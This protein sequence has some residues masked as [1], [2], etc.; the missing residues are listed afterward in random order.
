MD[1]WNDLDELRQTQI[2]RVCCS[3]LFF[4]VTYYLSPLISSLIAPKY[5]TLPARVQKDWNSRVVALVHACIV[6]YGTF[7][8]LFSHPELYDN[9]VSLYVDDADWY[10]SIAAGY[11]LWDL[12]VTVLNL[13]VFG[14][15]FLMHALVCFVVYLMCMTPMVQ[16][17]G[18]LYLGYEVSTPFL[19]L[20]WLSAKGGAP[21]WFAL[22]N[23]MCLVIV[24][25]VVRLLVG[26]YF[27]YLFWSDCFIPPAPDQVI[28]PVLAVLYCTASVVLQVLNAFW[29]VKI[30]QFLQRGGTRKPTTKSSQP[31][32]RPT[33]VD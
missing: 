25:C 3:V 24:F 4:T 27:L 26:T 14:F 8:T 30:I 10:I 1:Y 5:R 13:S 32:R 33:K 31:Q 29:F 23:G 21:R 22:A 12:I 2:R 15:G 19:N 28:P 9:R 17:Y 16:F 18:I 11:F 7:T 6:S 20:A